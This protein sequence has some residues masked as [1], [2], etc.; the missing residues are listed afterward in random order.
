[1]AKHRY[2]RN[3]ALHKVHHYLTKEND[4]GSLYTPMG[5]PD[6]EV[7]KKYVPPSE[8]VYSWIAESCSS[9]RCTSGLNSMVP[10]AMEMTNFGDE[11]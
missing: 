8:N 9:L 10:L 6:E 3:H 11:G 1:M 7:L 2:V 5:E 4:W